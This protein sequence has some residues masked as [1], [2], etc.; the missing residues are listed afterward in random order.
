M[1]LLWRKIRPALPLAAL[2]ALQLS[3]L[4]CMHNHEDFHSRYSE[5]VKRSFTVNPGGELIMKV[6]SAS[7][8]ITTGGDNELKVEAFLEARAKSEAKAKEMLKEYNLVITQK[9]DDVQIDSKDARHHWGFNWSGG[10]N[11]RFVIS[12]PSRYS[13]DISSSGGDI[14]IGNTTGQAILNTS[15]GSIKISSIDG[16]LKA[17]TSGGEIT[18]GDVKGNADVNTSGGD[19]RLG[20]VSG[21][22]KADTS[23]GS[24]SVEHCMGKL[25]ADTSGGSIHAAILD[26]PD[27][28]C[29]LDTSGGEIIVSLAPSLSFNMDASTSGGAVH[30]AFDLTDQSRDGDTELSGKINGGGPKLHLSTS[31]GSIY[32]KKAM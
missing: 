23:G 5:T 7:V 16:A 9:G 6:H 13:L 19:I 20:K 29:R 22:V 12:V 3:G 26:Q 15:G 24:I 25:D 17:D 8:E 14:S 2:L 30:C 28:D 31:G 32:I 18:V 27:E 4:G 1:K 10:Y 11:M 21:E